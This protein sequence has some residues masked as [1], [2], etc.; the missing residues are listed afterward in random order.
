MSEHPQTEQEQKSNRS[1]R[2]KAKLS[3][4]LQDISHKY[5]DWE[6]CP[7]Q[8]CLGQGVQAAGPNSRSLPANHK[9]EPEEG[10][11]WPTQPLVYTLTVLVEHCLQEF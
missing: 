6:Q 4:H 1:D 11:R 3:Q 5:Y 7:A 9:P 10:N 2:S 8:A